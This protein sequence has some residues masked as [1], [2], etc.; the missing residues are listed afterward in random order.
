MAMTHPVA[1]STTPYLLALGG[2]NM[3]IAATAGHPLTPGESIPGRVR[4]SPGGVARNV[5]QNLACLGHVVRL[6]SAVG[7]DLLGQVLLDATRRAGVDVAGCL[8]VPGRASP[9]YVSLFS[10]DG[11][12]ALAVNDMDI[13]EYLTPR[14]LDPFKAQLR[15]AAALVLDCNLTPATLEWLFIQPLTQPVFV[16]AVSGIKAQRLAPWLARVHLLKVNRAEA[17]ALWGRPVESLD[18]VRAAADWFMSKGLSALVLTLGAQGVYW[19]SAS[20]ECG[21]QQVLPGKVVNTSGAGDAL[22][23]ALVHQHLAGAPLAQAL[24]FASAC[25]AMTLLSESANHPGL[26]VAAVRAFMASAAANRP[27]SESGA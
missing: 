1:P 25:A 12:L 5:A 3:D 11:E 13:L 21:L 6:L 4:C 17:A 2:A 16:D 8:V 23:A 15:D 9:T 10:A 26:S 24:P 19:R 7:D 14:W 20:G 18:E 22:L 27:A